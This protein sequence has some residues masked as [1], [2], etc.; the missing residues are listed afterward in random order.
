M[1]LELS[2]DD[3]LAQ[4]RLDPLLGID[5]IEPS[6]LSLKLLQTLHH[7]GVHPTKLGTPLI[8]RR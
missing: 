2:L 4:L 6:V 7:L 5:F 3:F 1:A 8:K